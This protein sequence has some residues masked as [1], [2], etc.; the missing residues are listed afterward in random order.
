MNGESESKRLSDRDDLLGPA[1]DALDAL[2]A[3]ADGYGERRRLRRLA[4]SVR[5][6]DEPTDGSMSLGATIVRAADG[7]SREGVPW[8]QGTLAYPI[9]LFVT[10]LIILCGLSL[11]VI[12]EM[13][14]LF[15]S[16]GLSLPGPTRLVLMVSHGLWSPVFWATIA[17]LL[18]GV[19][20]VAVAGRL[21]GGIRLPLVDRIRWSGSSGELVAMSRFCRE[22]AASL[23]QGVAVSGAI[24]AA[25]ANCGDRRLE[26]SASRLIADAGRDRTEFAGTLSASLFPGNVLVAV[27]GADGERRDAA[28]EL[29]WTL[30]EMY[31]ERA[32]MRSRAGSS[33]L[34]AM[35]IIAVAFMIGFTYVAMM[36]P[37]VQLI[38]G[39][40]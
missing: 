8:V 21:P 12:P 33:L 28:I 18:A 20:I 23:S 10:A 5:S 40:S 22:F 17:V 6:G 2:A 4:K 1:S 27:R 39:L 15:D 32:A 36:M 13:E 35:M 19:G 3:E 34:A 7:T 29:L 38:T 16:F 30:A 14:S 11:L 9:V 25:G 31:R 26:R 37:L 24:R